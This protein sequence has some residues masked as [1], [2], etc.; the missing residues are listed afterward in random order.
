MRIALVNGSPKQSGSASDALLSMVKDHLKDVEVKVETTSQQW[1][2]DSLSEQDLQELEKCD[3]MALAFPLYVDSLPSHVLRCLKQ[4]EEYRR[5]NPGKKPFRVLAI[6]N[7]GFY[8]A[9]QNRPA[10]EVVQ[11]W[12]KH[13]DAV[14]IGG[15]CIGAGGMVSGIYRMSGEHGPLKPIAKTVRLAAAKIVQEG[16]TNCEIMLAEPAFP[17]FLYKRAAEMQWKDVAQKNGLNPRE[18]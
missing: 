6:V 9:H 5:E 12:C 8:N 16:G 7:N 13:A 10:V 18:L 2:R 14:F 11:N 17:Q 15:L 1:N 4:L 3:V